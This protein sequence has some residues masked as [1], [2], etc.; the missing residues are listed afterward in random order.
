[1]VGILAL[2]GD[3]LE[4]EVLLHKLDVP[5]KQVRL[6]ADLEQIDRLII[7]GGESTTIGKLLVLYNLLDPIRERAIAGMPVWGTCAGAIVLAKHIQGGRTG[8]SALELMD[9]TAERNAF[10][11]QIDSFE[12]DLTITALGEKPFHAVFIRAPLLLSPG[13]GVEVL[14]RIGKDNVVALKQNRLLATSFHPELSDDPRLHK[15]FLSL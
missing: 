9:M 6:P 3:F 2:Q 15:Y 10:G 12:T 1:M 7:P 8:Q 13:K 5:T 4:H 11:R 14:A